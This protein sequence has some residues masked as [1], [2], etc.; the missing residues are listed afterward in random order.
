MYNFV[1]L[2]SSYKWPTKSL[3]KQIIDSGGGQ[4]RPGQ[5]S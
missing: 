5:G 1:Q 4:C 2:F 3:I